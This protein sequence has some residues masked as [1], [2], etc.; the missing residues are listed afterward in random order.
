[1]APM[2]FTKSHEREEGRLLKRGFAH[3]CTGLALCWLPLI[4]LLFAASGFIRV[5][6]RLTRRHRKKRKACLVFS[7]LCLAVCTGVLLGEIWV[8]SRDPQILERTGDQIWTFIVGEENAGALSTGDQD[9]TEYENMDEAGFGLTD[10]TWTEDDTAWMEEDFS[11]WDEDFDWAAWEDETWNIENAETIEDES[12]VFDEGDLDWGDEDG[13]ADEDW[14]DESLWLGGEGAEDL[15]ALSQEEA[16]W[17]ESED[18]GFLGESD[19]AQTEESL[20]IGKGETVL[21]P[22]E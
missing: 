20:N 10:T 15:S 5:M 7:F 16:A 12:W 2:R 19:S 6:V 13:W 18:M 4:G 3:S 22:L 14:S 21:P 9:G 1:M 8:Y 17:L 11:A